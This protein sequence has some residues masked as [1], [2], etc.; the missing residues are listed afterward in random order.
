MS[1]TMIAPRGLDIQAS[2]ASRQKQA[3]ALGVPLDSTIGEVVRGLIAR[4]RLPRN[5]QE[6]A[7][8]HY[9]PL[10]E[11]EGRHLQW[12]E[13]VGDVLEN[14]DRIVLQPNIDAGADF[15]VA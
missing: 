13:L 10:L 5:D 8:I 1:T 4:M 15:P 9:Q 12:S 7:A 14:D 2:D 3:R 11:R 6:G